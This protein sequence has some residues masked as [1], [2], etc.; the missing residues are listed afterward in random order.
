[1]YEVHDEYHSIVDHENYMTLGIT[2]AMAW[3]LPSKPTYFDE[4][5]NQQ[6]NV[7]KVEKDEKVNRNDKNVTKSDYVAPVKS[8]SNYYY[9]NVPKHDYPVNGQYPSNVQYTPN[10]QYSPNG[11]YPLNA[12]Y[13][14]KYQYPSKSQY[15]SNYQY[16]SK[17]QYPSKYSSTQ[18]VNQLQSYVTYADT[19]MKQLQ[20]LTK[21]IPQD[22][23]LNANDFK[24]IT[25]TYERKTLILIHFFIFFWIFIFFS[26]FL[27]HRHHH[28][29]TLDHVTFSAQSAKESAERGHCQADWPYEEKL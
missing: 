13:S 7:E 20:Q 8:N 10:N 27:L 2:A 22:R 16:P 14:S 6:Y 19:L 11:Q 9:T 26:L 5:L 4:D 25:D 12:Q 23:P 21:Q 1:M 15:S 18:P 24:L 17:T 29:S 28:S 3:E